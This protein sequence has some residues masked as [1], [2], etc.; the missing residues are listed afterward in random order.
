MSSLMESY[1]EQT[2][3]MENLKAVLETKM[4]RPSWQK[5]LKI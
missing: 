3:V 2:K 5:D 1:N 4:K